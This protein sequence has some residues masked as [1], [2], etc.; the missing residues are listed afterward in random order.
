MPRVE[1]APNQGKLPAMPCQIAGAGGSVIVIDN[2]VRNG[3]RPPDLLNFN[4][5]RLRRELLVRVLVLV[6]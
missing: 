3:D 2:V 4:T 6:V 1:V 5:A